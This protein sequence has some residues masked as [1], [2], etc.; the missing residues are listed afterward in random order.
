MLLGG[1]GRH[2]VLLGGTWVA[3]GW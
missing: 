2:R 3:L 1:I